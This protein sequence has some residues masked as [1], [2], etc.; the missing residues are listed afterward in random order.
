MELR[1][2]GGEVRLVYR[3]SG[4]LGLE[5]VERRFKFGELEGRICI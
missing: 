4:R 2:V 1:E 3:M 5:F